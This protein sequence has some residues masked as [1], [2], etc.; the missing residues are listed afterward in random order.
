MKLVAEDLL[1]ARWW[2]FL[3]PVALLAAAGWLIDPVWF[4]V[5]L[6]VICIVIPSVMMFIYF[7]YSMTPEA[8]SAIRPHTNA[9][10]P[11]GDI[12]LEFKPDDDTERTYKPFIVRADEISSVEQHGKFVVIRLLNRPYRYV[13]LPLDE[14]RHLLPDVPGLDIL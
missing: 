10:G 5:L 2:L 1:T 9:I 3:V 14:F 11:D 13:F 4:M 8:V 7:N 12:T 6:M